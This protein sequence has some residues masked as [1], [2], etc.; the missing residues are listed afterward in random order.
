MWRI[1]GEMRGRGE[2]KHRFLRGEI[3]VKTFLLE[4]FCSGVTSLELIYYF[5]NTLRGKKELAQLK[6]DIKSDWDSRINNWQVTLPLLVNPTSSLALLPYA[7]ISKE[8]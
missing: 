6:K 1:L 7:S 2:G 4:H 3:S 8:R 5:N